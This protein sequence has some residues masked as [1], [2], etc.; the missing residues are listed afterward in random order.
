ME[1]KVAKNEQ[2]AQVKDMLAGIL[3]GG[4]VKALEYPL[5]TLKVLMQIEKKKRFSRPQNSV[6]M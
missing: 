1:R 3:S 4:L 5:D 6:K 2:T